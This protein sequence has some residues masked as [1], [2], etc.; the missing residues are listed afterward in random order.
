MLLGVYAYLNAN[1]NFH[2]WTDI[3]YGGVAKSLIYCVVADWSCLTCPCMPP[4]GNH[5]FVVY[6]EFLVTTHGVRDLTY[7]SLVLVTDYRVP[8]IF[9][10]S[11]V[12]RIIHT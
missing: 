4:R 3:I 1:E 10:S 2:F 12:Q 11:L 9:V 5:Q 6:D 8:E 7:Q